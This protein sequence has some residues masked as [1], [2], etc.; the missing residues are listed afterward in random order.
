MAFCFLNVYIALFVGNN[1]SW[2]RKILVRF[3]KF[4]HQY[5]SFSH[6][7]DFLSIS[8]WK[9]TIFFF[10]R[11]FS[12]IRYIE[13]IHIHIDWTLKIK[14][15]IE[16]DSRTRNEKSRQKNDGSDWYEKQNENIKFR[17][18]I[19]PDTDTH[20]Q[21]HSDIHMLGYYLIVQFHM[22]DIV[23]P[24][25][26]FLFYAFVRDYISNRHL[27]TLLQYCSWLDAGWWYFSLHSRQILS[28]YWH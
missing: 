5:F 1:W 27:A 17:W 18:E 8:F 7:S 15:K 20:T 9:Q 12:S 3:F 21:Q 24:D 19:Q 14:I 4:V 13:Y 25:R 6:Q 10:V 22:D 28:I 23:A 16:L 26:V 2:T 11:R